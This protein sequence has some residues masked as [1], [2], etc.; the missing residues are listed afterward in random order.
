MILLQSLSFLTNLVLQLCIYFGTV[1][2]LEIHQNTNK[3]QK[4]EEEKKHYALDEN[5]SFLAKS[6][7]VHCV[8]S[9]K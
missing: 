4:E 9:Q 6:P 3:Y 5:A 8:P 7:A 1:N 2:V